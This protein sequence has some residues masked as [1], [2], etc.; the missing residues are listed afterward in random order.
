[1]S[2]FN[3]TSGIGAYTDGINEQIVTL[4]SK[5]EKDEL[6]Y[7]DV[8]SAARVFGLTLAEYGDGADY[9]EAESYAYWN[10]TGNRHDPAAILIE[11]DFDILDKNNRPTQ[12]GTVHF[13]EIIPQR[14]GIEVFETLNS[15]GE[16]TPHGFVQACRLVGLKVNNA[17]LRSIA[18]RV[19]SFRIVDRSKASFRIY[20]PKI[21]MSQAVWNLGKELVEVVSSDIDIA[22]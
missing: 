6:K 10:A 17:V 1:M 12:A 16:L 4:R 11:Y 18:C 2:L 14:V 15:G 5:H 21:R 3:S 7:S 22:A 19:H 9:S 8:A 13:I 20:K